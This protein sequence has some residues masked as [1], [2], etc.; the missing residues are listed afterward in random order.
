M[1][2]DIGLIGVVNPPLRTQDDADRLWKG[3]A[4]GTLDTIGSDHFCLER[5]EDKV[6]GGVW[7]CI[8]GFTGTGAIL[9]IMME[10]VHKRRITIE[11]MAKVCCENTARIFAMYPKKGALVPGA[12]A[13]IVIID[14]DK[15]WTMGV[16][17]MK[18]NS[19]W[20]IW[21]GRKVKGKAIKTY[22]RGRLVQKKASQ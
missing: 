4:E 18:E 17:T 5:R 21:E 3:L 6:A 22:V 13:D 11:R 2:A 19:D 1:D 15:E 20:S 12:D 8:P 9:P 7:G 14:P 10:G 16:A